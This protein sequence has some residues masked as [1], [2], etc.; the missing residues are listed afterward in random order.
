MFQNVHKRQFPPRVSVSLPLS[1]SPRRSSESQ[2]S[3]GTTE[4]VAA[5]VRVPPPVKGRD[6]RTLRLPE[7]V[8]SGQLG[9]GD[10]ASDPQRVD[11]A[12][13]RQPVLEVEQLLAVHEHSEPAGFTVDLH[14]G[15]R[16]VM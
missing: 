10:A 9:D 14:L 5:S 4:R 8:T 2:T 1:L 11:V 16:D 6:P 13:H 3:R 12:E 15:E 7:V